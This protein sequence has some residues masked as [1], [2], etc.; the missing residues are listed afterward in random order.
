MTDKI[1]VALCRVGNYFPVE[2]LHQSYH[3]TKDGARRYVKE[4]CDRFDEE[5]S[6]AEWEIYEKNLLP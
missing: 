3:K 4:N 1:W 5:S 6:M 2:I